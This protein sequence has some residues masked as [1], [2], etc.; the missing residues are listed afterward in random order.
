MS[1]SI[2]GCDSYCDVQERLGKGKFCFKTDERGSQAFLCVFSSELIQQ[3]EKGEF[4]FC[5]LH[6][7][8]R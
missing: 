3:V 1:I 2:C 8:G 6:V 4:L 7:C 5:L